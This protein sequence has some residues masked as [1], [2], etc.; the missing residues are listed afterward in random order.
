M[1][2]LNATHRKIDV[3]GDPVVLCQVENFQCPLLVDTGSR[4][5]LI[6]KDLL[7]QLCKTFPKG[8]EEPAELRGITG[9]SIPCN[10]LYDL[11]LQLGSFKF[12]HPC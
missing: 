2:I 8:R 5:T 7:K 4:V 10:G 6:A 9:H 12:T 11:T 3:L 1:I